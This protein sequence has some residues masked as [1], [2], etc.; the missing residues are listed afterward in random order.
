MGIMGGTVR[1]YGEP[2]LPMSGYSGL[3][4]EPSAERAAY[5]TAAASYV[6]GCAEGGGL[7]PEEVGNDPLGPFAAFA[8]LALAAAPFEPFSVTFASPLD[9]PPQEA[10]AEEGL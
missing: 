5:G 8:P 6:E 4:P 2:A 7:H 1:A 10:E 3:Y 9:E